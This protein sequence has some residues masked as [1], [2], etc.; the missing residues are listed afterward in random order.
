MTRDQ[1]IAVLRAEE[2]ALQAR[3]E[4]VD[5]G[6]RGQGLPAD[7]CGCK[8]LSETSARVAVGLIGMIIGVP[9]GS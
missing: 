3:I 9:L 7:S 6:S 2:R 5:A 8:I 4:A 1:Q